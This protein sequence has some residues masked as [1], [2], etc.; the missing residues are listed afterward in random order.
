MIF[1]R[2]VSDAPQLEVFHLDAEVRTPHLRIAVRAGRNVT[3]DYALL[4]RSVPFAHRCDR[5]QISVLF[6]GSGRLDEH[7][8]RT[9]MRPGEIC[10]NDGG[11]VRGGSMAYSG[12]TLCQLLIEW[13]P[14]VFGV[15]HDR[16]LAT[17]TLS[18]VDRERLR[19]AGERAVN[20]R[21][22]AEGI[23]ELFSVL[24]SLG[25][26]FADVPVAS[27]SSAGLRRLNDAIWRNVSA[28]DRH[29]SIDDVAAEIDWNTRRV[30][31]G[32]AALTEQYAIPWSDWR[33]AL[34]IF[35]LLTATRLLCAPKATTEVVARLTGF[36]SPASLCHAFA[37][38]GIPSPGALTR[39]AR[40]RDRAFG[41]EV[42]DA[43]AQAS[44]S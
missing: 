18:S 12:E 32:I 23:R 14:N 5:P 40:A 30:H 10:L 20:E 11:G 13:D 4:G 1:T 19:L 28:L 42:L 26:P 29:P 41:G 43:W 21:T 16:P 24:R 37:K 15:S 34:H 33:S 22:S 6:D 44:L 2:R 8:A 7:G 17:S 31:R 35:R 38:A 36:R 9:W 25:L 27:E 39:A 3:T